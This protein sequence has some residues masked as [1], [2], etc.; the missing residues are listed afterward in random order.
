M[1]FPPSPILQRF[2]CQGM[3]LGAAPLLSLLQ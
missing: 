2:L 1:F 3:Q